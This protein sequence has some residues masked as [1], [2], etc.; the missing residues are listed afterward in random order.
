MFGEP[1]LCSAPKLTSL[2]RTP[3]TAWRFPIVAAQRHGWAHSAQRY[4]LGAETVRFLRPRLAVQ[5]YSA[6]KSCY[7]T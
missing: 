4:G 7:I 2:Y 3:S 6:E 1:G 5:R